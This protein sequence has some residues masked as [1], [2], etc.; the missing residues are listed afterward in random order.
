MVLEVS[1]Y[2][3]VKD[4]RWKLAD[5]RYERCRYHPREPQCPNPPVAYLQR[6]NQGNQWWAYCQE[7]LYGCRIAHGQVEIRVLK[8]GR[9][10]E[11]ATERWE[12]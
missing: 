7:H 11:K 1:E 8:G 3:W 5:G 12:T 10:Y 9:A 4:D 6:G 2:A